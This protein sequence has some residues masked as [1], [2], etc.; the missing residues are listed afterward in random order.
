MRHLKNDIDNE[1][2]TKIKMTS[3]EF[4]RITEFG[5]CQIRSNL[6]I[7]KPTGFVGVE[8]AITDLHKNRFT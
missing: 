2:V 1:N 8:P 7:L 4:K 6:I 5:F 3:N